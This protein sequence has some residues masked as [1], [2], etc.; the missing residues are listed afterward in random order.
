MKDP[1]K[2]KD[3]PQTVRK[4]LQTTYLIK[5][6]YIMNSQISFFFFEL[7]NFNRKTIQF[8]RRTKDINRL[9]HRRYTEG[10]SVREKMFH[11]R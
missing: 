6:K 3:K 1:V 4:Y 9:H 10:R 8:R 11:Y 7:S 5:D 2:R